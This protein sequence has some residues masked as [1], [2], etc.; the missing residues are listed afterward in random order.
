MVDS[1]KRMIAKPCSWLVMIA[2]TVGLFLALGGQVVGRQPRTDGIIGFVR[3][4]ERGSSRSTLDVGERQGSRSEATPLTLDNLDPALLAGMK[5]RAI[6]PAAMS[7]RV[8]AIDAVASNPNIIY[9]G[10]ASGGVWKSTD[11]GITWKP[12]FDDQPVASIGAIAIFQDNPDIVWVGTGEGNPRNSASVGNGVYKSIDGGRT[13]VHLGLDKT[14]RIHRIVL[15]PTNPQ[16]AY[17][18]ALGTAWGENAERGVFKTEDGGRTWK[19]ILYVD[20]RTG[21]TDLVM[22]PSNPNKL[23]AAMWDYRRWPWFFRSGGPGSGLYLT[24]DGGEHWK[25]LTEKEGLPAGELGR[26]GLAIAPSDPRIVYALVEAKKNVLLRSDDGGE[27]W[28]VVGKG[29]RVGNRPFYFSEIRVDPENPNRVYSLWSQMSV[30]DDGG[31]T[32][33]ILVPFRHIHPDH[34]ALWINPLD[35]RLLIDGN[36]GGVAIS[37]DR[38]RSWRFV[39]NLPVGQFYHIRV[40][41]AVPYHVYGGMQDNGSWKGPSQVWESGGIRN[42]HWHEVDFGDGFDTVPDPRDPTRGYAM[43][44]EGYLVRWDLRTGE[45]KDIR[46]APPEGVELRFN[47]NAAL[48]IDP[49]DPDTIYFGSQF[50][51]RSTDRGETWEII[52]PDLTTNNP[53]WQKQAES[54][55]LTPDVTGAENYTTIVA[56]APSPVKRGVIWVGTDDGRL[57]VTRDGGRSW[58][59]VEKNVPGVPPNTWVP[60]IEPSRFDAATA[61]VV[62]DDHRR[63]NWTPYVYKTTDYGRTWQSLATDDIWGYALVIVQDPV[64]PDLLFLGTEFGLYVSF[65]GGRRWIRW[66]R[67]VPTV[68]VMDIAI[69]PRDHDLILGTHG[70][71]AFILDDIRPL[72]ELSDEVLSEPLHLFTIPD[73]QQYRVAQPAGSRFPGQT[74]FRGENRPY[75]ALITYWLNMPGL[76]RPEEKE[77]ASRAGES[78]RAGPEEREEKKKEPQVEI[79]ITDADGKVI[80]TFK[81]PAKLGLNRA[82][83]DLRRDKFKEPPRPEPT[84]FFRPRGPE[85]PPGVYGVTITFKDHEVSG[86]VRILPDPRFDIAPEDRQ[87]NYEALLRAGHLQE[88]V[89]TAVERIQQTRADVKAVLTKLKGREEKKEKSADGRSPVEDLKKAAEDL[90]QKLKALE[91][92]FWQPPDTK[93]I[94]AETDVLSRLRYVQRAIASHWNRPTPAQ[95]A[96]LNRVEAQL[97]DV[98]RDFNRFFEEDVAAFRRRVRGANIELLPKA[99][100]LKLE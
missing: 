13:W 76:P 45:R 61:F 36:D 17:V 32:F 83:W 38:G 47:W 66:K 93:G 80:R 15:H 27:T 88:I 92:R 54:G 57:H 95:Q 10:A 59:S 40:D 68:S 24:Y 67:G 20:E 56:I 19:K 77:R 90:Q 2:V 100:P 3:S 42:H 50:V 26:I 39:A 98:L 29:R 94:V 74:D 52:S 69:H 46:P 30:S 49:F 55:G 72:A 81:G 31:K 73:A 5:A 12:I 78:E 75:G 89:A 71:S 99:K 33:R 35:G 18:A 37:R 48:A 21:A 28:R 4:G 22:D 44:Q 11:G 9:V 16:I 63:A 87:A 65:N 43:S 23:L 85:V 64:N 8:T 1:T 97:R 41:N 79:K 84:G 25:R 51:H 53:E 58:T 70:R 7:G 91:K 14:E 62:F 82:V 86:K 60:H 96:Y 6:G 34:H